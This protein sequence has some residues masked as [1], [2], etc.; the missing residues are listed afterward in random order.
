MNR[1]ISKRH[2]SAAP[3]SLGLLGLLTLS[4]LGL[5]SSAAL[6]G[7]VQSDWKNIKAPPLREFKPQQPTRL[8]LDN[9]LTIYLQ[10]NPELPLITV[11]GSIVGGSRDEAADKVG[12]TSL[13][14]QTLRSGGVKSKTGDQVDDFLAARA[15]TVRWDD[16]VDSVS[17]LANFHKND[18]DDVMSVVIEM[19]AAPQFQQDKL[20][21][22][23]RQLTTGISRRNDDPMDI[24]EREAEK[25]ALG[26]NH[27]HARQVE[28][29]TVASVTREDLLNWHRTRVHPNNMMI[30]IAG[31]FDPAAMTAK[32]RALFGGWP[33]G[34][35]ALL[36][37][38]PFTPTKPGLYFV[39]KDDVNQSSIRLVQLGTTRKNPD[40]YAIEVM[41]EILGGGFAARLFTNIRSKKAL[42]YNVRGGVGL[43][44]GYPA[45]YRLAM[46]TASKNTVRAVQALYEE[47]NA[48]LKERPPTADELTKAKEAI[49][50]S[51]V[52]KVDSKI[53]VLRTRM[54][55][56]FY[57]YPPDYYDKYQ[58]EISKITLDDVKRVAAKYLNPGGF[59]VLV[60]GKTADFDAP[61]STLGLGPANALDISIPPPPSAPAAAPTPAQG[62]QPGGK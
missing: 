54:G 3:R 42:A 33:R 21:L 53:R 40:T 6:A 32:L 24:A 39:N 19:L 43:E 41:N 23:K 49:L 1:P 17:L 14:A 52:F 38:I 25:L 46:G 47:V 50:N 60:V 11:L 20:D 62:A 34:P 58:A 26:A 7:P 57:G 35:Q 31:D 2:P 36:A 16:E 22:A 5:V 59:A 8:Q 45:L 28:Y 30:G 48:M 12:L 15:A 18:F 29:A 55:F 13:Y 4:L 51:F 56:D 61:L 37:N 27:P 10:P 44:W 9:G